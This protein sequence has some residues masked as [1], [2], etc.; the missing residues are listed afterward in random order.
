MTEDEQPDADVSVNSTKPS[1]TE[2]LRDLDPVAPEIA[3]P[4]AQNPK[5]EIKEEVNPNTE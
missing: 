5:S 2:Q 1:P 3:V 4:G